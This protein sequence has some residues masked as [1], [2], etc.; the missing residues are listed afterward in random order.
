MKRF[1]AAKERLEA[2]QV[3]KIAERDEEEKQSGRKNAVESRKNRKRILMNKVLQ[4][5]QIRIVH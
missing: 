1:V 3:E 2:E 4:I 5:Q